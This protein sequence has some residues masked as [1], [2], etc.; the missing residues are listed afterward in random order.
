MYS[1]TR[2]TPI[3]LATRS[4][5]DNFSRLSLA[6]EVRQSDRGADVVETLERIAAIYGR[7]RRMRLDNGPEF[8]SKD[9]DLWA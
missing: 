3:Q 8:I 5:I 9:L 6:L 1:G 7:P 2:A 4:I